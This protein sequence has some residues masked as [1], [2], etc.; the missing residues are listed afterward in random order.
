MLHGR[1]IVRGLVCG[2]GEEV[3]KVSFRD[4][5]TT[6]DLV[7]KDDTL[8]KKEKDKLVISNDS[9]AL[10]EVLETLTNILLRMK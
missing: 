2:F 6:S 4:K 9:Y 8:E 3:S 7:A 5:Y 1:I 10:N